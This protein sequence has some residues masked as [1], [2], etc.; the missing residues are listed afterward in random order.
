MERNA[1]EIALFAAAVL[2]SSA[3]FLKRFLRVVGIVWS[4]KPDPGFSIRP[5]AH[6]FKRLFW[7]VLCQAKVIRHRP[8]PGLAHAFVFWGFLTFVIVTLDHFAGGLGIDWL[9]MDS[10]VFGPAYFSVAF[11]FAAA[12]AVS[13]TGLALRRFVARP[14]W[15]GEKISWESGLIA[16][17]I[18]LLMATYMADFLARPDP[19]SLSGKAL[20]WLHTLSLL[21]FLPLIPHSKHLHLILS[22]AAVFLTRGGFSR[23][24]PLEGDEDFGLDT[25]KDVTRLAALQ[26]YSCVECGRCQQHCPANITGKLLNPKEIALG[27]RRYL[28][29]NGAPGGLWPTNVHKGRTMREA[30]NAES[31]F[32]GATFEGLAAEAPLLGAHLS[33]EA[34][35][36]CTTCGA[37]ESQCPVGVE[38]LPLII[39]LRRGAVNTGKWEDEHGGELFLRLERYGNPLGLAS[40]ERDKFIKANELPWFDGSQQYCLWLGCMGSFDPRGRQAV[41]ALRRVMDHLGVT[42]GVLKKEKCTGDSARRLGNDLAFQQLAGF[43]IGQLAGA[44]AS[45]LL[46]ICPHCVRTIGEDWKEFGAAFQIEHH[47]VFLARHLDNLPPASAQGSAVYHDPCYLGRYQDIYDEPRRVAASSGRLVEAERN[48]DTSFCC[49]AGGGLVFL[50]EEKGKRVSHERAEQLLATGADTVAAA[51]PFCQTMLGD[52]LTALKPEG[53][54][55]LLD[56]AEIAAARLPSTAL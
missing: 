13:I 50:G 35:F 23:I 15:L 55:R 4:S 47:S 11:L 32:P 36:Q 5:L 43:N 38:H 41:L 48:R 45:R 51:C 16:L 39:G 12:V 31:G 44:G 21:V 54:P 33:E 22:P 46:S 18:F 37:C 10:G 14:K 34:I 1:L 53:A 52:A 19:N 6:R 9:R 8:L 3:L 7:D 17:L 2:A 42:Y 40:S 28:N 20:W 27:F 25:G 30:A 49:G 24:P 56:I 26:A 29:E